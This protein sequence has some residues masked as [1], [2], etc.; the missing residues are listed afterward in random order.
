MENPARELEIKK[1]H[2]SVS[3][4]D[5]DIVA[6][7]EPLQIT[8]DGTP[9]AVVMRTPRH[10]AE[11]VMGFLRTEGIIKNDR[12]VT[13]IDLDRADN[14]AYVFLSDE[15]SLDSEKL[16][17][18]LYS[19]SS[20]GICGKASIEAIQQQYPSIEE[21]PKI[22]S[23]V[24]FGLPDKLRESQE[25]FESTGGLH[26]AGLFSQ[27]GELLAIREDVGRHNALDKVIG[28]CLAQE[29]DFSETILLMS[30]RVSFEVM[31]KALAV[32]IPAVA[33]IS[34]PTSL[35]VE[36]ARESGQLLV[37]FLRPPQMNVYS[38]EVY[39]STT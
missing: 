37:G 15:V 31:Q 13:R 4:S 39:D 18:N 35:A 25:V 14:H 26:A 19:A 32:G 30:G 16:R 10:D 21:D 2:D 33:A 36:F 8:V 17:R 24:L 7:E 5:R 34:A 29:L 23:S 22:G 3:L 12:E 20:C 28:A 9:L 1:W 6:T 38:G 11:L 27:N